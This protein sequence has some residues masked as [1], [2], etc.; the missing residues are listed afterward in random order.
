MIVP[1]KQMF[2]P[3]LLLDLKSINT[4]GGEDKKDTIT[5][6][7]QCLLLYHLEIE[8]ISGKT[9]YEL[10]ITCWLFHTL[11]SNRVIALACLQRPYKV[12]RS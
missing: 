12:G 11:L 8:S 6:L 3:S 5:P 10:C 9:S 7:T 2:I 1:N 4:I